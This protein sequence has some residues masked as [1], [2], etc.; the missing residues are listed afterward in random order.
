MWVSEDRLGGR[1][2][3]LWRN[4][5]EGV[6]QFWG[7][8]DSKNQLR[9]GVGAKGICQPLSGLRDQPS[10]KA[11]IPST[12]EDQTLDEMLDLQ[13]V[14]GR[15]QLCLQCQLCNLAGLRRLVQECAIFLAHCRSVIS[16]YLV[17]Q[18]SFNQI[19]P[20]E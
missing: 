19:T 14:R 8:A 2:A 5:L 10:P 1:G 7:Y 6:S 9:D 4:H 20:W 18:R 3:E 12:G 17:P 13:V 15:E 16:T 11:F